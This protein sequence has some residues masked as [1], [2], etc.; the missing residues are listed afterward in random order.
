MTTT[1]S[2][3]HIHVLIIRIYDDHVIRNAHHWY[4]TIKSQLLQLKHTQSRECIWENKHKYIKNK[5]T[6]RVLDLKHGQKK[7]KN[8]P[9]YKYCSI[10]SVRSSNSHN[11]KVW[12]IISYFDVLRSW[13][14]ELAENNENTAGINVRIQLTHRCKP[15]FNLAY[16]WYM[17]Y[18]RQTKP[19][20]NH[21][22]LQCS[23]IVT[24]W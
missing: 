20:V 21:L 17:A 15:F 16:Q 10:W 24:K 22:G 8:L 2:E 3:I 7:T 5:L 11:I 23:S 9:V 13:H 4:N 18:I 6:N 12:V 19:N 14:E 1:C